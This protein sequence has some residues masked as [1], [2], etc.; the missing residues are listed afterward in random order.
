MSVI[1]KLP[2]Y[3]AIDLLKTWLNLEEMSH[4]DMAFCCQ[5]NRLKILDLFTRIKDPFEGFSDI[6][7]GF[8]FSYWTS[9]RNIKIKK[10]CIN[11]T[12]EDYF[13]IFNNESYLTSLCFLETLV[14]HLNTVESAPNMVT[15]VS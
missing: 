12:S 14:I 3:L 7:V 13:Y 2:T 11:S 10:L 9:V 6:I 5:K 1:Y 4:L 15:I 8:N